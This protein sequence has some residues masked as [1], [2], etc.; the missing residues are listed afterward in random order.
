MILRV[1]GRGTD[2]P[3]HRR[4]DGPGVGRGEGAGFLG[5]EGEEEGFGGVALGGG[6]ERVV[7]GRRG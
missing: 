1:A 7:W 2:Q 5:G 4:I 6:L 3:T